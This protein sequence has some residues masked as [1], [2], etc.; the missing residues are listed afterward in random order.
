MLASGTLTR[1]LQETGWDLL[2][3][4]APGTPSP[5]RG[6]ARREAEKRRQAMREELRA[7]RE[8]RTELT[9]RL[10]EARREEGKALRQLERAREEIQAIEAELAEVEAAIERA[11]G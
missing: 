8:R 2:S 6:D 7:A 9:R 10:R 1:E 11:G 5:G 4:L 3:G